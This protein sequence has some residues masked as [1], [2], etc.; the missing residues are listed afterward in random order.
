M[1]Q[2]RSLAFLLLIC[3]GAM[4][5]W[6]N[7]AIMLTE[8]QAEAVQQPIRARRDYDDCPNSQHYECLSTNPDGTCGRWKCL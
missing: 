4:V 6:N 2:M 7:A 5:S 8:R 3:L 1:F